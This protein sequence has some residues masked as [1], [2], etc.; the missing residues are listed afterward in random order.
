MSQ[1]SR[2][3]REV[4]TAQLGSRFTKNSGSA[5]E[6]PRRPWLERQLERP[7]HMRQRF[8]IRYLLAVTT[9]A[10]VVFAVLPG[11]AALFLGATTALAGI[12]QLI[13]PKHPRWASVGAGVM[14]LVSL[15][16][17]AAIRLGHSPQLEQL[18]GLLFFAVILGAPL[19]YLCG[20]VVA[21]F[22]LLQDRREDGA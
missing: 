14:M 22:S 12:A 6:R 19:G 9:A 7:A 17:F 16:M 3:N 15:V 20:F 5:I 10:A 13:W 2:Q 1:G 11:G 18:A 21:G 4:T 8:G